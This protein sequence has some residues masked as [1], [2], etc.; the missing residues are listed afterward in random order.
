VTSAGNPYIANGKAPSLF[1]SVTALL[2]ILGFASEMT[3]SYEKGKALQLLTRLRSAL[4]KAYDVFSDEIPDVRPAAVKFW[5]IKGFTDNIVIGCPIWPDDT[6]PD[7]EGE[8]GS[9]LLAIREY[10]LQMVLAG[11]FVRGAVA[12]GDL[13]I[14]D[15]VVFGDSLIEAYKAESTL[16]RDP[17]IVL[18][19]TVIPFVQ[20]QI[21]SWGDPA[22]SPHNEVLLEDVDRQLFVNYLGVLSEEPDHLRISEL[23]QHKEVVE[24]RLEEYRNEPPLWSKYAWVG[25]YHNFICQDVGSEFLQHQIDRQLLRPHP[26]RIFP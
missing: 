11:F 25:N 14:D 17:R 10:Q 22:D 24:S 6:F 3:R 16:A 12:I 20:E 15:E 19:Q 18:G 2:D 5:E 13:Y 26:N 8:L 21:K 4:D 1:K 7:A 23:V 9:V